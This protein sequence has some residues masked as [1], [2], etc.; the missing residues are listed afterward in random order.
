MCCDPV[1]YSVLGIDTTFNISKSRYLT[2]TV[3][4]NRKLIDRQ[5]GNHPTMPGPAML[6]NKMN[7]STFWYFGNTLVELEPYLSD[8][9]CIGSDRD[10]AIDKVF[11]QASPIANT[12]R[13]CRFPF[14]VNMAEM[15]R[16]NFPLHFR[17]SEMCKTTLE[18]VFTF[19][20]HLRNGNAITEIVHFR[21]EPI[22]MVFWRSWRVNIVTDMLQL[23]EFKPASS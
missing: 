8:I 6:H 4:N 7:S 12:G 13:K 19:P 5:S 20:S 18:Q 22:H 11:K 16:C 15:R 23:N 1:A 3:Y 17:Q 14:F 21:N 9:M 2:P 10:S